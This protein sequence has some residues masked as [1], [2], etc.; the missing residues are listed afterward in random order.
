MSRK[1]LV[2]RYKVIYG[3]HHPAD[4]EKSVIK[5]MK[6]GWRIEGG[7]SIAITQGNGIRYAQA[8]S[9]QRIEEAN[10]NGEG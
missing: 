6:A 9:R 8:M 3:A 4:F 2:V 10:D 1:G 5:A 7:V